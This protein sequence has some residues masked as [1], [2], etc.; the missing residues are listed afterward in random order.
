MPPFIVNRKYT[1]KVSARQGGIAMLFWGAMDRPAFLLDFSDWAVL[2]LTGPDAVEFLQGVGTQDVITLD[3]RTAKPTLFLNEKGRPIA[4]GWA[5]KDG[6]VAGATLLVEPGG[7]AALPPHFDRLRV[8]E[9]VSFA[10]PDGM[11]RLYGV[12]GP[13]R[14]RAARE[15][16]AERPGAAAFDAEVVSFLLL[17]AEASLPASLETPEA[18]EAWRIAAGLPRA[19]VDFDSDRIATELSLPD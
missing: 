18:A 17:P 5:V 6:N 14:S 19:G 13:E 9:D 11:P 4:L 2:R 8:M 15:W 7:A 12:A 3:P 16:A 1:I 10:G